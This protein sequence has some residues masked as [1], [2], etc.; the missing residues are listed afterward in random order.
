MT[1]SKKQAVTVTA[2][3]TQYAYKLAISREKKKFYADVEAE[4]R[5][6]L[7]S[8]L[9]EELDA[10]VVDEDG[11]DMFTVRSSTV[12]GGIDWK[13]FQ[14]D[15]PDLDYDKYRKPARVTTTVRLGAL[16]TATAENELATRDK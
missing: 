11:R 6:D 16:L 14:A 2:E 15:H 8:T 3:Q 12:S 1:E 5:D 4:A 10:T 9:G 7:L 13:A